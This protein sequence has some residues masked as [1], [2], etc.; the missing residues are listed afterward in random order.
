MPR[1]IVIF[2]AAVWPDGQPS[3]SLRRRVAYGAAAA[4][5]DPDDLVFCSGGVGRFGP[6]EASL[7]AALL[8]GAGIDPA[9]IVLDEDS[10]DTLQNVVAA[11]RFIRAQGLD[12]ALVCTDRY[13]LARV[14]ML[15][16]ALGVASEPG[17]IAPGRGGT[18]LSYWLGMRVRELAAFPYDLAV[19]LRRRGDL[20]RRIAS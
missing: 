7:M 8:T 6:S 5:A 9:R 13:H 17:P 18:R 11:A 1:A 4:R 12:G 20:L 10:L 19:V 16:A 14:R 2:G 3:P 15:F